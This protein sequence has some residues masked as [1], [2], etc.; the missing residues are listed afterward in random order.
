VDQTLDKAREAMA[1]ETQLKIL[2]ISH[3]KIPITAQ[4][5]K[6]EVS[7]RSEE[8]LVD[9]TEDTQYNKGC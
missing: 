7:E 6:E 9:M 2:E 3:N 4:S 1:A 8:G 5:A